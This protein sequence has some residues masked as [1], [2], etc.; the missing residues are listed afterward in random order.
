MSDKRRVARVI[1][2][3]NKE[4]IKMYDNLI[5]QIRILKKLLSKDGDYSV[6]RSDGK[7]MGLADV[8]QVGNVFEEIDKELLLIDQAGEFAAHGG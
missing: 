5:K 4:R 1:F 2:S 6:T 8:F 7:K 3:F